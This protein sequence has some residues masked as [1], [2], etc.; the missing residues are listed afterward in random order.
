[1]QECLS[2]SKKIIIPLCSLYSQC[3]KGFSM[4]LYNIMFYRCPA[5]FQIDLSYPDT[6]IVDKHK[7]KKTTAV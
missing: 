1:M 4:V 7:H 5:T 2:L 6:R 3:L